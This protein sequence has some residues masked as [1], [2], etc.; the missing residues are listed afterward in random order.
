M[1]SEMRAVGMT[2]CILTMFAN[3]GF[4]VWDF[5]LLCKGALKAP[6]AGLQRSTPSVTR[7]CSNLHHPDD[8]Q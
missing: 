3:Q 4:V 5:Q 7:Q 2:V 1:L 8:S 6:A